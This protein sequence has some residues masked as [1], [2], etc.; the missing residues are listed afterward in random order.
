MGEFQ[1][2]PK[3]LLGLNFS[4]ETILLDDLSHLTHDED[5]YKRCEKI[6]IRFEEAYQTP[7]K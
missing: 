3:L 2:G 5:R 4:N 1:I 6:E 7:T